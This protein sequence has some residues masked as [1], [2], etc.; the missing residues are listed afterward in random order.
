MAPVVKI[1]LG[2]LAVVVLGVLFDVAVDAE[3]GAETASAEAIV[4]RPFLPAK[5]VWEWVQEPD[6]RVDGAICWRLRAT[7]PDGCRSGLDAELK[8]LGEGDAAIG[9]ANAATGPLEPGQTTLLTINWFP[10]ASL[11][12]PAT[13]R[14]RVRGRITEM[15]CR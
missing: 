7:A 6:C 14:V 11:R 13:G 3:S 15:N 8:V 12:D 9:F 2:V 1:A 4:D 5:P 10:P